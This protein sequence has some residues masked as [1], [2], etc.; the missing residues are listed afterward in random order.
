MKGFTK[1]GK[2]F[3][4]FETN[5]TENIGS[6]GISGNDLIIC[7]N[8]VFNH[9]RDCRDANYL[10]CSDVIKDT[11]VLPGEKVT[12]TTP[13]LACQDRCLRV[14]RDS[15]IAYSAELPGSPTCLQLFYNDGGEKGDEVIYGTS[16][17]KVGLVQLTRRGPVTQWLIEKDNG[18]AQGSVQ[19]IDNYDITGDGVRDLLVGRHDGTIEVYSYEQGEEVVPTLKYTMVIIM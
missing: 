15:D 12:N 10:L 17:G 16:D 5:L 11:L 9:Y 14:V 1:K 3:L 6:M 19:T 8:H 7:G 13:V 18:M 4:D 2:L